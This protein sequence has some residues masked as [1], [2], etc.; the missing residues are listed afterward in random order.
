MDVFVPFVEKDSIII[1]ELTLWERLD[2]YNG[3][4]FISTLDRLTDCIAFAVLFV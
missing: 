2:I 1:G 3:F 4:L